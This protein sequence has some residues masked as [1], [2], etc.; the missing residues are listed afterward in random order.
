MWSVNDFEFFS[1]RFKRDKYNPSFFFI[2]EKSFLFLFE[3]SLKIKI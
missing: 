1:V 2:F 3:K